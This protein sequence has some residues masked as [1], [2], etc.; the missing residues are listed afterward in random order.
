MKPLRNTFKIAFTIVPPSAAFGL[1]LWGLASVL[2]AQDANSMQQGNVSQTTNA[3]IQAIQAQ[4]DQGDA[5]AQY[6]LAARY[7]QGMGVNR[8]YAKAAEYLRKAANQGHAEAQVALG[9]YYA[10]GRGVPRDMTMA[11]SWYRKAA[12]QG[13]AVGQY[14]MGN[15]YATGRGVTNDMAQAI[16]WWQKAA[17]QGSVDA[18]AALGRLYL[19]PDAAHGTN[20]LNYSEAVRLL[21]LAAAPG[22]ADAMNNL[23]VAYENQMGVEAGD[24]GKDFAEAAK[25]YRAAAEQGNAWAQASLGQLYLDGRGVD[26]DLVQAYKWL[27]LSASQGNAVGTVNFASCQNHQLLTPKQLAEAEQLVSEFHPQPAS[28]APNEKPSSAT[29]PK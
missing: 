19:V 9:S 18:Q 26:V 10:R 5:K 28:K 15:F 21:R 27:K 3:D 2:Q 8:S 22:S 12:E 23:G 24:L 16:H 20:Y 6:D 1:L 17:E 13:N 25:W 11:V 4:A 14:A 7:A 29:S